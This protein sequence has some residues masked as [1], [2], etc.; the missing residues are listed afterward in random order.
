[1]KKILTIILISTC[2]VCAASFAASGDI[3]GNTEALEYIAVWQN[4]NRR[5]AIFDAGN[6]LTEDSAKNVAICSL[7]Q[8][9]NYSAIALGGN[10]LR[11][12]ENFW[13]DIN[14][15]FPLLLLATNINVKSGKKLFEKIHSVEYKNG[16]K[17][18]L[19]SAFDKKITGISNDYEVED[20]QTALAR[21]ISQIPQGYK[22]VLIAHCEPSL[23]DSLI[24]QN[25]R[26]DFGVQGH[27]KNVTEPSRLSGTKIVLQF[28][29][30]GRRIAVLNRKGVVRWRVF[31]QR[32]AKIAPIPKTF[33][34]IFSMSGCSYS[35][36]A[37]RNYLQVSADSNYSIKVSF[38][39]NYDGQ[40]HKLSP[41]LP[42]GSL[43]EEKIY[44]AV[45]DLF[46]ERFRDFLFLATTPDSDGKKIAE[47]IGLSAEIFAKWDKEKGDKILAENYKKSQT[48]NI[49]QCPTIFINNEI[50]KNYSKIIFIASKYETPNL[51]VDY[52]L[53][54]TFGK[55][56]TF[57]LDNP[58]AKKLLEN[59]DIERVP[60]IIRDGFVLDWQDFPDGEYYKRDFHENEIVVISDSAAVL[61]LN[62]F[63]SEKVENLHLLA[64]KD[65]DE[66]ILIWWENRCLT[67]TNN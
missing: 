22:I 36:D 52:I 1:M 14:K 7:M 42:D 62:G 66:N 25:P 35:K 56:D 32:T 8:K 63:F 60:A 54:N 41:G 17:Y 39:G 23:T 51:P 16:E 6:F 49:T 13:E 46:P 45:Q 20:P 31:A 64:D 47:N 55:I 2:V 67:T 58:S 37:I 65:G 29:E 9:V 10:E 12:G 19:V 24:S 11:F 48:L 30:L 44:L 53:Q 5:I 57:F 38:A 3:R 15:K 26:I 21:A 18:A 59:F 40:T 34:E 43:I 33:V 28:G 4:N 61:K 50:V 27:I